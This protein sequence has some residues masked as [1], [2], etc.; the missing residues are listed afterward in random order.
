MIQTMGEAMQT[1]CPMYQG[2]A[3][4]DGD[5]GMCRGVGT[6]NYAGCRAIMFYMNPTGKGDPRSNSL[7]GKQKH[8]IRDMDK[9]CY[10]GMVESH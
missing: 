1:G 5:T 4:W 2:V 7:T 6:E 9:L 3:R 10:C 8:G